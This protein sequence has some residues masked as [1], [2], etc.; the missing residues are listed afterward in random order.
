MKRLYKNQIEVSPN[1][2]GIDKIDK[3]CDMVIDPYTSNL[4]YRFCV[5]YRKEMEKTIKINNFYLIK[6]IFESFE[7]VNGASLEIYHICKPQPYKAK[8]FLRVEVFQKS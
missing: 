5:V 1:G 7:K 2:V 8:T 6:R 4:I 3:L